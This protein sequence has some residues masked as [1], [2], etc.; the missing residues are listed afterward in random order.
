MWGEPGF[1]E[2]WTEREGRTLNA[3]LVTAKKSLAALLREAVPACVT[4]SGN[5]WPIDREV[6]ERIAAR[7]SPAETEELRLP[8]WLHVSSELGDTCYL[9]DPVAGEV[10]RRVESFGPAFPF[11]EGRM[12]IPLSLGIDLAS[13]DRGAVQQ[14]FL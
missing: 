12:H 3:D 11:R 13:R 10:L 2:R 4:R 9:T 1:I 5:P 7:C 6:L 8:I 14:V